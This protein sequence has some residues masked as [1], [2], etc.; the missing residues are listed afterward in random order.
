LEI[1]EETNKLDDLI[2][3]YL[4]NNDY[5][6]DD[7]YAEFFQILSHTDKFDN[8]LSSFL[9]FDR[10]LIVTDLTFLATST[11][12]FKFDKCDYNSETS[13]L[14]K[15]SKIQLLRRITSLVNEQDVG[16][17]LCKRKTQYFLRLKD[18]GSAS[19]LEI[20]TK[21]ELYDSHNRRLELCIKTP[22]MG[23]LQ[24]GYG[25]RLKPSKF[26]L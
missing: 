26:F 11:G 22:L 7:C 20:S 10:L 6:L 23:E 13:D 25:M 19:L 5:D 16:V 9:K 17:S 3:N 12:E 14:N 2:R 8:E 4:A 21:S 1:L 24:D 15:M 18:F